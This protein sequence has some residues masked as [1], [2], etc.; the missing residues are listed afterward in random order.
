MKKYYILAL[1]LAAFSA[2]SQ[3]VNNEFENWTN[4]GAYDSLL[5]WST[6]NFL[7][8]TCSQKETS[9]VQSG[10]ASLKLTTSSYVNGIT[11]AIPGAASTGTFAVAGLSVDLSKGGQPDPV[12]HTLLKGY[13]KYAPVGGAAASIEVVLY[14]RNGAVRDTVAYGVMPVTGAVSSY[15][16][17]N[18]PLTYLK[19]EDPDSSVVYFQSSGRTF[20]DLFNT[21]TLGSVLY[22]DS[23]Y[24]EGITGINELPSNLV[25]INTF[26]NPASSFLT[27]EV[28]WKK[29]VKVS[30]AILDLSGKLLK[31]IPVVDEKQRIDVSS[32]SNGNYF[33]ELVD[34]KGSKLYS[35]KFSVSH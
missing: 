12:R 14:K 7:T 17:F 24:F 20:T 4:A 35:G 8:A 16:L 31:S 29:A 23:V 18:L 30:V 25:S 3:I 5:N 2:K 19:T 34:D 15:T 22:I 6:D 21:T 33:Y 13:Y 32:L 26:P 9:S 1:L 28:K 10:S 11:A 27:I